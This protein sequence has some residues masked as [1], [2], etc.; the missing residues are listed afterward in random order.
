M[1]GTFHLPFLSF[2]LV[3]GKGREGRSLM[4]TDWLIVNQLEYRQFFAR[5][6]NR[7]YIPISIRIVR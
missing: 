3:K 7:I 1:I 6:S 2:H 4:A 5:L